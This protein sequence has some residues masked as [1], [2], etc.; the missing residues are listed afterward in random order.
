M[1]ALRIV[2]G[3]GLLIGLGIEISISPAAAQTATPKEAQPPARG[4]WKLTGDD[5]KLAEEL[6]KAIE[7]AT[8]ADRWDKAIARAEEL[9]ALRVRAHGP[10]HFE[11]VNTEWRRKDVAAHGRDAARGS[12]RLPIGH[13]H[14]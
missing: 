10:K 3:L 11:T 7:G 6:T 14:E 5:V 12:S 1:N 13:Y 9:L 4:L 2:F 8:M